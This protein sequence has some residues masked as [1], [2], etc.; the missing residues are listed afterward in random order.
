[1]TQGQVAT[2]PM[3]DAPMQAVAAPASEDWRFAGLDLIPA[4]TAVLD[5]QGVIQ[6]VN[7]AWDRFA[8]ANGYRG[9][10]FVGI[11][12]L[13]VCHSAEGAERDDGSAFAAGLHQVLAG[14]ADQFA[15]SYPCHAPDRERWYKAI[16]ESHGE[17]VVVCHVDITAEHAA[18]A[19]VTDPVWNRATLHE[20]KTPL[21]SVRGFAELALDNLDTGA[22]S[23]VDLP[24]CLATIRDSADQMLQVVNDVLRNANAAARRDEDV[25]IAE[26]LADIRERHR[27]VAARRRIA[28]A[29]H[30]DG[31]LYVRADPDRLTKI[32]DNLVSNAVKYS[33]D[34]GSVTMAGR[35]NA[36]H[37]VEI[38]VSDTGIGIAPDDLAAIFRPYVRLDARSAVAERE[39]AGLG[40]AV[41]RNLMHMHGGDIRVT[42]APGAGS[43]F[44]L[45]FPS[46]RTVRPAPQACDA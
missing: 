19:R 18:A 5:R 12:Y 20:L 46:W 8:Q 36:S 23:T 33:T 14:T 37:G 27:G 43:R 9:G 34:G 2:H 35:A 38:S 10:G 4:Q 25:P 7:A 39:G 22:G 24:D 11:N 29:T 17:E 16:V 42:S 1:M 41:A 44:T 13:E 6:Y 30:T 3:G 28:I 15:L 45:A 40:L 31:Q 21:N 32:L 26:I